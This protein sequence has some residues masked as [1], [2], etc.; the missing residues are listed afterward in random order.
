MEQIIAF[1][2]ETFYFLFESLVTRDLIV[3]TDS[4]DAKVYAI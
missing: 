4:L 1:D 2:F 3:Y